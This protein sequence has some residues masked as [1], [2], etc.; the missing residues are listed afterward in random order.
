M[1]RAPHCCSVTVLSS[2]TAAR[3]LTNVGLLPPH[4]AGGADSEQLRQELLSLDRAVQ[5][6]A[7]ELTIR[8]S[9]PGD[10]CCHPVVC[11]WPLVPST[12]MLPC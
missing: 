12:W 1:L 8:V 7:L 4:P 2:C 11:V 9:V 5:G 10:H 3:L 6:L